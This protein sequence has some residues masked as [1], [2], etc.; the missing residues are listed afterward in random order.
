MPY[1]PVA[2]AVAELRA[3]IN[4]RMR[5]HSNAIEGPEDGPY[6]AAMA[7]MYLFA[8]VETRGDQV[9]IRCQPVGPAVDVW[10]NRI[11]EDIV[12]RGLTRPPVRVDVTDN[13]YTATIRLPE[14]A[15]HA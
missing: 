4:R 15:D 6:H 2:D 3:Y 12:R 10:G 7:N 13:G 8:R 9:V 11:V 1:E 5:A 14:G